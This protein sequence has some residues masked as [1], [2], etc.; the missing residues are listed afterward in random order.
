MITMIHH[1]NQEQIFEEMEIVY[2]YI[3]HAH[4]LTTLLVKTCYKRYNILSIIKKA[5]SANNGQQ[6]MANK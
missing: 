6:I 2:T 4:L 5:D 3:Q 1:H